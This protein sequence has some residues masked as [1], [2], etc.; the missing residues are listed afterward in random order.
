MTSRIAK[1]VASMIAAAILVPTNPAHPEETAA[2]EP[3][4][5][6]TPLAPVVVTATRRITPIH[7]LAQSAYRIDR[8]T[9]ERRQVRTMPEAL[10]DI[11]GVLVQKTSH[12]QGSPFIRGFTG[13]SNLFLIDGVRFNNSILR[14][15]PNEYWTL[16][17]PLG[18]ESIELLPSSGAILFGS[19][20][21][22]GTLQATTKSAPYELYND[23]EW[24]TGGE[25]YQRWHS[26]ENSSVSRA[27]F[28]IGQGGRWGLQLG[29]SFKHFGDI[30]SPVV[31]R[32]PF[33]G[34]DQWGW[35][36]KL[37]VS[38]NDNWQLTL[39]H[40]WLEQDD[41]WRT[42]STVFGR[43]WSGTDVGSDL[44]RAL[45]H[46]RS[47]SYARLRGEP[48]PAWID[49]VTLTLSLQHLDELQDRV[50]SDGRRTLSG[51]DLRTY[52]VDLQ[53]ESTT[54]LGS[55]TYGLDYYHDRVSSFSSDF[56]AAGRLTSRGVQGP[57]GDGATYDLF[58]GYVMLNSQLTNRTMLEV[59]GR[60]TYAAADAARIENPRGG[61]AISFSDSF[62]DLSGSIRLLQD[63][64]EDSTWR[65]FG[66][67][68]QSFRAPNLSDVSRLDVARSGELE[69]AA[70]GL[71]PEK[72]LTAEIGL[73]RSGGRLD[74]QLVFF[75]TWIDD[76]IVRQPTGRTVDGL[77]EVTKANAGSGWVQGVELSTDYRLTDEWT[78][79]GG[80]A[81]QQGEA[82]AF[83]GVGNTAVREPIGRLA[84]LT[85]L[86]AV[87]FDH[88]DGKWGLELAARVADRADKLSSSDRGDTQRIP[89]GGTP[90]YVLLNLRG[91]YQLTNSLQ[92]QASVDNLLDQ[93]YRHHGSGSNEPGLGV[94]LGVRM[95]F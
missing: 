75:H 69:T 58:G 61:G 88:K 29:G 67:L 22:G 3:G 40:Q 44:R 37:D 33:T 57:V 12:G 38:L 60:Y 87:R 24:F 72:Y 82:D 79:T 74:A 36:A 2:P 77:S 11:P 80:F 30:D 81:W 62:H 68:G 26:S 66:G 78:L 94:G 39:F 8:E 91:Y 89:P 48:D 54:P 70:F 10:A 5:D 71:D 47:L 65:V 84:P 20:A 7:D 13:R 85:G 59:G 6:V 73:R 55:L 32:Q 25:L 31:G 23:G 14:A 86:A 4:P 42:H 27:G 1:P 63:L 46:Q 50:R 18:L 95:T 19:D 16:V 53:L 76:L 15:G 49:S 90:G 34:Y 43:S 35:D 64:T 93:D 45:D 28:Y 51:L 92:V 56:D 17:D 52:G 83:P 9:L 41:A 21:I